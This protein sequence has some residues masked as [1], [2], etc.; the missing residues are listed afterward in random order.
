MSYSQHAFRLLD[1][2]TGL[3]MDRQAINRKIL[4]LFQEQLNRETQAKHA[5]SQAKELFK[6][7]HAA[8]AVSILVLE[9]RLA[10]QRAIRCRRQIDK[11]NAE[12]E[13]LA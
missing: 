9:A 2:Q 10:H 11:L 7:G 13:S 12:K 1:Q 3:D 8:H 4:E 5:M 6:L